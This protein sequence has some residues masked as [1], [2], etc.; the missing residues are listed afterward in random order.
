MIKSSHFQAAPPDDQQDPISPQGTVP[1]PFSFS[2][3]TFNATA[4]QG[5]SVKIVD[6]TVFAIST[7]IAMAEVTVEPGAIR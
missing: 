3:S 1:Q 2:L 7:Q 4:V 6:S 5:G